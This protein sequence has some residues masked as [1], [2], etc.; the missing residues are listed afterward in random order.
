ME[1]QVTLLNWNELKTKIMSGRISIII[2]SF[3]LFLFVSCKKQTPGDFQILVGNKVWITENDIEFY[4]F[5]S[6]LIYLKQDD[7]LFSNPVEFFKVFK[8]PFSVQVEGREIYQGNFQPIWSSSISPGASIV[9]P[10]LYS[11]DIIHIDYYDTDVRNLNNPRY[12]PQIISAMKKSGLYR[13][14]LSCTLDK[15]QVIKNEKLSNVSE[16]QFTFT[17]KNRDQIDLYILDP[18]LMGSQ[19]FHYFSNGL[20]LISRD[21]KRFYSYI[22]KQT[23]PE[24]WDDWK[25]QWLYVLK[26]GDQITRTLSSQKY[27]YI[28]PGEYTGN[29]SFPG[30]IYQLS[31]E[32]RNQANGRIWMGSVTATINLD[33]IE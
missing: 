30:L 11:K 25:P 8:G 9:I 18:D 5:S 15:V 16:I 7:I 19:L 32:E 13:A 27:E 22:G 1:N 21:K 6:Q 33:I 31:R 4:D 3:L 20:Y 2:F 14:G 29:F 28:S 26:K 10:G 23:T 17:V 12:D 24:P